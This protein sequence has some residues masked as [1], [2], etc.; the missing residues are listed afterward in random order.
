MIWSQKFAGPARLTGTVLA[1]LLVGLVSGC[2]HSTQ[3]QEVF[4]QNQAEDS[5]AV[6]KRHRESLASLIERSSPGVRVT[7]HPD[8]SITVRIRGTNSFYGSEEPLYV[9]DGVPLPQGSGGRLAGIN[10]EDIESIKVLKDAPDTAMY[11]VRGANGVIVIT[12]KR[13]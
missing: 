4:P 10:P 1:G 13:P 8:G 5:T 9:I 6:Q 11:G 2:S 7:Q 12:T 3:T